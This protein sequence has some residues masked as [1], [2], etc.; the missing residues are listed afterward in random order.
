M[1]PV[2]ILTTTTF[3]AATV[4]P[5]TVRFGPGGAAHRG[6]HVADV[7]GDGDRD[8]FLFFRIEASGIQCGDTSASLTGGTFGG[9]SI[10]RTDSVRTVGC[11]N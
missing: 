4:D 1:L 3:D 2:A 11:G 9:Q 5:T 6:W 7:D 10:Q 8:L